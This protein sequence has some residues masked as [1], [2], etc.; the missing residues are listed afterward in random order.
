[1]ISVI[2]PTFNRASSLEQL[3]FSLVSQTNKNFEWIIINDGSVDNTEEVVGKFI[4]Q[5]KIN[6][7]YEYQQNSGKHRALN[8]AIKIANGELVFFVDSDDYL[9]EDCLSFINEKWEPIKNDKTFAGIS[10]SR[11]SH[12][13]EII[14]DLGKTKMME[15]VDANAFEYRYKYKVKGDKAEVFRK[16]LIEK[17]NFPEFLDE[18]FIPEALIYNRIAKDGHRLRWFKKPIYVCEYRKDGLTAQGVNLFVKSWNG[19]SLYTKEMLEHKSVSIIL[20]LKLL[21]HYIMLSCKYKK[22]LSS[23]IRVK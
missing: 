15:Y 17:Y 22:P 10:A 14:G 12:T 18:K 7:I 5:K 16:S 11:V 6:I 13:G 8:K 20:K 2:T 1:M 3:Y 21:I 23:I 9:T 19:Y 4:S